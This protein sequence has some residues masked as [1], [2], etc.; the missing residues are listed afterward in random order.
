MGWLL[1]LL[2]P[3]EDNSG[4]RTPTQYDRPRISKEGVKTRRGTQD[5]CWGDSGCHLGDTRPALVPGQ[6]TV[7]TG[8]G[9]DMARFEEIS[10]EHHRQNVPE[11]EGDYVPNPPDGSEYATQPA[12][13][14]WE[15]P[16]EAP[17]E[18]PNWPSKREE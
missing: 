15:F 6:N 2:F 3:G 17:V 9:D 13:H 10:S 4:G 11:V 12:K 7:H 1:R 8:H 5:V 14:W 18:V 16:Q